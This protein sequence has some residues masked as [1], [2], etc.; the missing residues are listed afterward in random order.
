LK[1]FLFFIFY[2]FA[3]EE[4]IRLYDVQ[5]VLITSLGIRIAVHHAGKPDG[6]RPE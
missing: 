2:A 3:R 6:S 1:P 5:F 4:I